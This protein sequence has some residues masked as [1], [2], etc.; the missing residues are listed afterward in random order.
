MTVWGIEGGIS[1][2]SRFRQ[3]NEQTQNNLN[4]SYYGLIHDIIYRDMHRR[5]A[6]QTINPRVSGGFKMKGLLSIATVAA[7]ALLMSAPAVAQKGSVRV[8]VLDAQTVQLNKGNL[9]VQ[10]VIKDDRISPA[11]VLLDPYV[12]VQSNWVRWAPTGLAAF[13]YTAPADFAT[14]PVSDDVVLFGG[15]AIDPG[16]GYDT[17]TPVALATEFAFL[18]LNPSALPVSGTVTVSVSPW[19]GV[20]GLG[21]LP[22]TH[23]SAPITL[24]NVPAGS[25]VLVIYTPTAPVPMTKA[26]FVSLNVA[27]TVGAQMGLVIADSTP[28]NVSMMPGRGYFRRAPTATGGSVFTTLSQGSFFMTVRGHYNFI[29]Q[30]DLSALA[31]RARPVDPLAF[32]FDDDPDG[33]PD[34]GIEEAMRRNIVDVELLNDTPPPPG[35]D[36]FTSRLTTYV[37]ENGRFSLPAAGEVARISMRRWDNA[38]RVGYDRPGGG[39]GT[40]V[41]PTVNMQTVFVGDA[42]GDGVIDDADILHGLFNFGLME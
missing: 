13:S 14:V 41:T 17:I 27:P 25:L 11:G 5:D 15:A 18:L 40:L 37:D 34:A 33:D 28:G 24:T 9:H 12:Y 1:L 21:A 39:W 32:Q 6:C 30:M 35:T 22:P 29:G 16:A 10:R 42:N 26:S 8:E 36:P 19:S 7:M 2:S 38:L 23:V 31:E 20:F 3:K 4:S